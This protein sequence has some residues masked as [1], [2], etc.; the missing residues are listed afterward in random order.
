MIVE[1]SADTPK[2]TV[3]SSRHK[4]EL[5]NQFNALVNARDGDVSLQVVD[6]QFRRTE[7]ISSG[8][9]A[10]KG[11][12][13]KMTTLDL[14]SKNGKIQDLFLLF[15]TADRSPGDK[16]ACTRASSTGKRTIS[17]ESRISR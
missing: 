11:R 5:K 15:I 10:G 9:I 6:S 12:P 14:Y 1:G 4:A 13:G 8:S 17:K 7:V 16:L 3:G 2:F